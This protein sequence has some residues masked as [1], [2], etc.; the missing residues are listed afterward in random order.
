MHIYFVLHGK[1]AFRKSTVLVHHDIVGKVLYSDM[2]LFD[3]LPHSFVRCLKECHG[4]TIMDQYPNL[5]WNA[6]VLFHKG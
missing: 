3:R 1:I 6:M 4:I 5:H 2:V